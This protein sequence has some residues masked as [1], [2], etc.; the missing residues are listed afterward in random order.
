MNAEQWRIDG[1]RLTTELERL[2]TFSDTP[3]PAITRVMLSDVDLKA[4]AWFKTLFAEANL[5]VRVDAAGNMFA[6]WQGIDPD[7]PAIA[8]GSH[9]DAIP[10]SGR[11]D[12][13][14]GVLGGL[15]AI[16]AL[17][18]SGF[19]P[20]RSIELI[21]FTSEEPTRY[22]VGCL[23]SR[24]MS[25]QLDA[26]TAGRLVDAAGI[27]FADYCPRAEGQ[28]TLADVQLNIGHYRAFVELHIEQGPNL[29]REGLPIGVVTAIAAPSALRVTFEGSG[30]HA[31][32]V[33]MPERR[34]ALLPAAELAL[35]VDR[36]ARD[37]G[38]PDTVATMG[39][40][41]VHP[42]AVNSIPSR[43]Y[44]EID[45]R[46][47]SGPRRDVVLN[48]IR[49][50]AQQIGDKHEQSTRIEL[51]NADPPATCD[52]MVID[53]ITKA[54]DD[55]GLPYKKMISRAYH[56]SLFMALICPMAMIFVPCANGY[57]HRPDEFAAPADT[58]AG[59]HV[60]AGTLANLAGE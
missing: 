28:G 53:A 35:E 9:C 43:T 45:V 41:Q 14:V 54:C 2:A 39:L 7:L 21:F 1:T 59:A 46:D 22:G 18:R 60:L 30:G 33:L 8:T 13:T 25:G 55:A 40:L 57:S 3:S 26:N 51:I 24:I 34:D 58:A 16:R 12:G 10:H 56:D 20:Q 27:S 23:G 32:A 11:F 19:K 44:M 50:A 31:G 38:G 37:I 5:K 15:E 47:I 48:H 49:A 17:Q 52:P 36:A 6:R 42:G 4:R 29:E